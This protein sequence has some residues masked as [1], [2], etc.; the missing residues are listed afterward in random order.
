MCQRTLGGCYWRS[1]WISNWGLTVSRRPFRPPV[2]PAVPSHT[3]TC[4]TCHMALA[5]SKA[6]I[7]K[8]ELISHWLIPQ[9]RMK[10]GIWAINPLPC[11]LFHMGFSHFAAMAV[12]VSGMK[13]LIWVTR[14]QSLLKPFKFWVLTGPIWRR[15]VFPTELCFCSKGT[16]YSLLIQTI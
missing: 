12:N 4:G 2:P 14:Q 15:K 1:V 11:F 5:P 10:M 9:Q 7:H 6:Q 16:L 13:L 8:C 3:L